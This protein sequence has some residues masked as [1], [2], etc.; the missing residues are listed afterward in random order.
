MQ[1][2]WNA[3]YN[4]TVLPGTPQ[5]GTSPPYPANAVMGTP[6]YDIPPRQAPLSTPMM[7]MGV[8]VGYV[9]LLLFYLMT[10]TTSSRH[11]LLCISR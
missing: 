7:Q 6:V 2:S 3:N 9:Y 4:P 8:P 1:G 5:S 10:K 11:I